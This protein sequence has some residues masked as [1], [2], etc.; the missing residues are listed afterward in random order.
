[1]EGVS[2]ARDCPGGAE[3]QR[4]A[5]DPEMTTRRPAIP[6]ELK[7][8]VLYK[9]AHSCCVCRDGHTRVQLH[10]IDGN[11]ANNIED[12]LVALCMKHHDEAEITG[13]LTQRLDAAKLRAFKIKWESEVRELA[14][15]RISAANATVL[16]IR[17]WCYFNIPLL[18]EFAR[19]AKVDVGALPA[20]T[21]ARSMNV[22][23]AEYTPIDNERS[24]SA[25]TLFDAYGYQ[26]SHTLH[27][28]LSALTEYTLVAA[29]P[30]Q[31]KWAW[32]RKN[33]RRLAERHAIV[34]LNRAF[35][36]SMS[37]VAGRRECRIAKYTKSGVIL[38]F[39][40]DTWNV[41]SVS[42]LNLHF[43]GYAR[44][45][46]VLRLRSAEVSDFDGKRCLVVN[47]TPIVCGSG[48]PPD[49]D[50]PPAVA[51]REQD[52]CDDDVDF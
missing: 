28:A 14:R 24:E 38:Q 12:N 2:P 46:A 32:S 3:E 6:T 39:M 17:Q 27:A 52:E 10:H 19:A 25:T 9:A 47:A 22:L 23:S 48:F 11:P 42:A 50:H 41:H 18:L 34:Y 16:D 13:G 35:R 40:L 37:E 1:M 49:I 20:I 33:L 51:F 45:G 36:Y 26:Q 30:V 7:N 43:K 29:P 21:H 31:L 15:L 4:T 8:A 5:N 44:V